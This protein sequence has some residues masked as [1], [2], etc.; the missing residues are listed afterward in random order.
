MVVL[1]QAMVE[2]E[3]IGEPPQKPRAPV[4]GLVAVGTLSILG[5]IGGL[6]TAGL[7]GPRLQ[8][9]DKATERRACR[10][11]CFTPKQFRRAVARA[12]GWS[13]L[14][15]R[16]Y[17]AREEPVSRFVASAPCR[18]V[19]S[20]VPHQSM[21]ECVVAR[22]DRLKKKKK[23]HNKSVYERRMHGH[24][25]NPSPAPPIPFSSACVA[26]VWTKLAA[27]PTGTRWW[28]TTSTRAS[29]GSPGAGT[30]SWGRAR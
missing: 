19:L 6:R 13:M 3:A 24:E 9:T 20:H 23:T 17:F 2:Y 22:R 1:D 30:R 29:T 27:H 5:V 25:Q 10:R 15:R 18:V 7:T 26:P 16:P 8:S 12:V 21:R 11:I 28:R 14:A 4:I